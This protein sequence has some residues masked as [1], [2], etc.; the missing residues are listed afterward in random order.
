MDVGVVT[1][2]FAVVF[3]LTDVGARFVGVDGLAHAVVGGVD[4]DI[5]R[6]RR[7]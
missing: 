5:T 6:A 4:V 7:V 2:G 1:A 3:D